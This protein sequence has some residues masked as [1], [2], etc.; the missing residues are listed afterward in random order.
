M[1]ANILLLIGAFEALFLG[2]LVITKQPKQVSDYLLSGILFLNALTIAL[3]WI[4]M[5]NR[6]HAY[7][8]PGLINS[9][10]PFI[11][12][13]GPFLWVYVK[14]LTSEKFR[15]KFTFLPHIIPFLLVASFIWIS[16]YELPMRE[17]ILV[18]SEQ[19]F[20]EHWS[21]P[22]IVGAIFIS[23]QS[24]ILHSLAHIKKY[25]Y[26]IKNYFSSIDHYNLRWLRFVLFTAM[27][28]YG[29]I[30]LTYI[31]DFF[32]NILPYHFLQLTGFTIASVYILVLGF[33]GLKQGNIFTSHSIEN[34]PSKQEE[35][36][37]NRPL[38]SAEENF[39]HQLLK[40]MEEEQPYL[41]PNLNLSQLAKQ[42]MVTPE[43][44]SGIL[45]SR[46]NSSFFDFINQYRIEA[47]KKHILKAD[48]PNYTLLGIAYECGFNSKATFNRVFKKGTGLTPGE[49]ARQVSEK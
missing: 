11:L 10:T 17:R 34:L 23:I 1:E 4:E 2:V 41:N 6:A 20:R 12:L 45:N 27:A 5:Y 42:L 28:F 39:V 32:I 35:Y 24:Y 14:S 46:L 18:D 37:P 36:T 13:H 9:S 29:T 40:Q 43:Y 7:P 44:L 49:Y 33:Y 19:L 22:V 8:F 15:F 26:K 25:K 30:S 31:L 47:F 3:S 38:E 48:K 16:T 21:Y